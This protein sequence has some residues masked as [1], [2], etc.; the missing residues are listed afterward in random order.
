MTPSSVYKAMNVT[1]NAETCG[2]R[3]FTDG[4]KNNEKSYPE[5]PEFQKTQKKLLKVLC[6]GQGGTDNG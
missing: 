4:E 2:I 1:H 5:F 3:I 6:I